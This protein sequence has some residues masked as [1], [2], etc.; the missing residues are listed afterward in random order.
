MNSKISEKNDLSTCVTL[1]SYA[2]AYIYPERKGK[3]LIFLE[4]FVK[5]YNEESNSKW[6]VIIVYIYV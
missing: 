1:V 3:I 5:V 4:G 6:D 2:I